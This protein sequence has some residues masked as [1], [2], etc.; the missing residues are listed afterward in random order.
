MNRPFEEVVREHGPTVVRV[1]RAV[2]GQGPDAED[3]WSE[4]FLA[5]LKAWPTLEE[6]TNIEAWLVRVATRKAIDVTRARARHALPVA[7][8]PEKDT[9][10]TDPVEGDQAVWDA[11]AR[12]PLRQRQAITSHY[13]GGLS[14]AQT[15]EL[16]GSSADAVRRAA[17][18]GM[19]TL[20][21]IYLHR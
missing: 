3:A 12:L 4:T 18:A 14:H 16:V 21:A 8:V 9:T 7:E 17:A 15:A 13:I 11:V 1:C 6:D 2:L 10:N 20:R 5:A 19:K